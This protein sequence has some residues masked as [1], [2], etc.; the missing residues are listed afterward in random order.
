[1]IQTGPAISRALAGGDP[2]NE[3]KTFY[4]CLTGFGFPLIRRKEGRRTRFPECRTQ[5][6][7]ARKTT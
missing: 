3:N 4:F 1:L 5:S 2:R 7:R 6:M